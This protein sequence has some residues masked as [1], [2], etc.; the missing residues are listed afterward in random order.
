MFRLGLALT[1]SDTSRPIGDHDLY[2]EVFDPTGREQRPDARLLSD[3]LADIL[4]DIDG[5]VPHI[6]DGHG[7]QRRSMDSKIHF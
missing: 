4:R 5:R 1:T 6:R 7:R 2:W 3:D